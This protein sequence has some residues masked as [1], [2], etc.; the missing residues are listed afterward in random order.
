MEK[1]NLS[2]SGTNDLFPVISKPLLIAG[3]CSAESEEQ[4]LRTAREIAALKQVSVLRAGVW[5]PRSRPGEFE[6][7][8]EKALPWLKAASEETGLPFMVEVANTSHVESAIRYG[9]D[10]LW[11]GAR[12]SVNPFYVQ[13]IAEALTGTDVTVLVKNP[14]NPDLPLWIGALERMNRA[15]IKRLGAIHRGFSSSGKSKYRNEPIWEIPIALKTMFPE[16]PILCDPSHICGTRELIPYISQKAIDLDMQGLMIETHYNPDIA[17]TDAKQQLTPFALRQLCGSLILR[18]ASSGNPVFAN[19][20]EELRA[21]IDKLDAE[22]LEKMSERMDIAEK[23]GEYKK[24]NNVTILQ[25]KRWDEIIKD[26]STI[27]KAMKLSPEFIDKLLE[28]IHAE[29]IKRQLSVMNNNLEQ[30]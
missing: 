17:L 29:S 23:I 18:N 13:E 1:P 22:I 9:I 8:G 12:T 5:K 20:L 6:G 19:Q 10:I 24:D 11:I 4:V 27:G 7:A 26:R 21:L 3:P 30:A 15:G 2:I 28:L 14:V 16:L 25:V